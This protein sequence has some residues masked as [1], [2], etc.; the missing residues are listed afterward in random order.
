MKKKLQNQTTN[1]YVL[2]QA[3]NEHRCY[4]KLSLLTEFIAGN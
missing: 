3:A 1:E 4:I 2:Y